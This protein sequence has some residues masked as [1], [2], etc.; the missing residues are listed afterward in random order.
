MKY[1]LI[2]VIASLFLIL[3]LPSIR[4]ELTNP[5]AYPL[6][7]KV[8]I[9]GKYTSPNEWNDTT[10]MRLEGGIGWV[11]YFSAKYDSSYLYTLWDFPECRTSFSGNDTSA[12]NQVWF[13]SDPMNKR[14][15]TVDNTMY[16]IA[17]WDDG[18]PVARVWGSQ[19][20]TG[21][22]W[23]DWASINGPFVAALQYTSSPYSQIP[24]MVLELRIGLTFADLKSHSN[25]SIGMTLGFVDERS[26]FEVRYPSDYDY[27]NPSTWGTLS[28]SHTTV[29]E[30]PFPIVPLDFHLSRYTRT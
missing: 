4:A 6:L 12:A 14:S 29:P 27:K 30:F 10:P 15:T 2:L 21:G 11:A 18:P 17:A 9:D 20:L 25:S 13:Y 19:G 24:H 16:R 3:P 26:G 22:G 8:T 7:S 23:A 28:F 5:V 1:V